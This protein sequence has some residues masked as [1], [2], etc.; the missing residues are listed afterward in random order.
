MKDIEF[1]I[2]KKSKIHGFGIFTER[3]IKKG[4]KFYV[5]PTEIIS[6]KNK[7]GWA[8]IGKGKYV[9]DEKVLNWVNHSCDPNTVLL[10]KT[11]A[12]ALIAKKNISAGEEI[13]CDYRQTEIEKST[14]K[15]LCKSKKCE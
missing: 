4:E 15:C 3:A 11:N 12:P 13:V 8:Y 5:I 9:C 7:Y 14:F 2:K 1:L 10:I 6:N